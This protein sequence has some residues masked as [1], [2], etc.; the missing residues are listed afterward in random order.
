MR[1]ID[2]QRYTELLARESEHWGNVKPDAGNPQIWHDA[3]LFEI[4]FSARYR[5]FV[6][7]IV[8]CGPSVLELGCGEGN[9]ALELAQRNLRVAAVDLSP[10]RIERARRK[11]RELPLD[12]PPRFDV[13]DLNSLTLPSGEFDCIIAH[14]VLHHILKIDRLCEEVKRSLKNGG[15]FLVMDYV[16]MGFIRK[17]LAALLFAVLPTHQTYRDKWK[18]RHRLPAFIAT[19]R[20]KREALANG[21][22]KA[23]HHESPFE[24]ISQSSIVREISKRF[25][26]VECAT[27]SPFFFYLAPKVRLPESVRYSAAR[28]FFIL[29][30]MLL[31]LR[32]SKG[33]YV[34]IEARKPDVESDPGISN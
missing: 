4:F 22:Q 15:T 33:A 10:D 20:R 14:D 3:R 29:D 28:L 26:I 30:E 5:H 7:R 13:G 11:A 6:Q 31:R 18:L 9:L 24:E 27:Y 32:L 1:V 8:S 23:L 34:F 19:E 17:L 16:G 12:H 21:L 2:N 25:S